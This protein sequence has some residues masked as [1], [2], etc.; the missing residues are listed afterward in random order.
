[1]SDVFLLPDPGEGLTEADIVSWKVAAGDAVTV[2][3]I[4]VE[5]ETAKSLV[6]LPSP[7]AGTIGALLV[8]E[9]DTVAVGTPIVRFGPVGGEDTAPSAAGASEA[10]AAEAAE[11]PPAEAPDESSGATLVG[12][13]A[14]ASSSKRRPRKAPADGGAAPAAP[15]TAA[16]PPDDSSAAG[17][18]PPRAEAAHDGRPLAKPPV[19]KLAKDHGVDL[20]TVTPTGEHGQVTRADLLAH[21][22]SDA[23]A[24]GA[25]A[26]AP[27]SADA[28]AA[29]G[30]REERIPVKGVKKAMANAMVA[31]AFTSPHVTIGVDVDV[32]GM[33]DLVRRL[34]AERALGDDVRVS[35]L[36]IIAM[37]VARAARRHPYMNARMDG[38]EVVLRHYVNL[39][40]AAATERG[41]I[42][43]NVKGADG[44][45]LAELGR[46]I[47]EL[48][49][50]ARSGKTPPAAQ[51]GGT[52]TLTNVGVFGVDWGT[53]IIN[54][55]ESAI[56]AAGRVQRRPWVVDDAVVPR[57]VMTLTA[58]ADH[59]VVDG[60]AISRFLRDIAD[61]LEDPVRLV[62]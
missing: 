57:E 21:L 48:V 13:G 54:P 56:V 40:I 22:D 31:S 36:L 30:E 55:G 29:G 4:L 43:P 28:Q 39:G 58:S 7:H 42:V 5:V 11:A 6:E 3:Q 1:M 24:A 2:N 38:D 50:V 47:G 12:Y 14:V 9:G 8:E 15:A 61:V 53:P 23:A 33:M 16:P 19:R 51:S 62:F 41:L 52:I 27:A 45:G 32:T 37:A 26:G 49:E 25:R 17:Q 18:A 46:G 20:A 44:M 59:R 34:K 35:P 10:D 60:E